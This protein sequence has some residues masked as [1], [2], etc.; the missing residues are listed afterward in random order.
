MV[1]GTTM[2]LMTSEA[3][4]METALALPN[5]SPRIAGP[6]K[7]AAGADALIAAS[8]LSPREKRR[9]KRNNRNTRPY[10]P[11][12]ATNIVT[13]NAT[14]LTNTARPVPIVPTKSAIGTAYNITIRLR[15]VASAGSKSWRQAATNPSS[16]VTTIGASAPRTVSTISI[17][18]WWIVQNDRLH[19]DWSMPTTVAASAA[20]NT[21]PPVSF[22][23][24][25]IW[26]RRHIVISK[27][28]WR[29]GSREGVHA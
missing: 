2:R 8:T 20:A 7:G 29:P 14:S 1:T 28:W 11:T 3:I 10:R 13:A 9:T 19:S 17:P 26:P 21:K 6:I 27:A 24:R 12:T 16:S 25:S 5:N 4:A 15:T 22:R 23:L 18:V